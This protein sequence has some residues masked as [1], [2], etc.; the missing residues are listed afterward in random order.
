M[1]FDSARVSVAARADVPLHIDGMPRCL[2]RVDFANAL[3]RLSATVVA[4]IFFLS[5][6][7][8][9][10]VVVLALD[11]VML[12]ALLLPLALRHYQRTRTHEA[13]VSSLELVRVPMG[14][15]SSSCSESLAE[16]LRGADTL[17]HLRGERKYE[18]CLT[19]HRQTEQARVRFAAQLQQQMEL[20][21]ANQ[22]AEQYAALRA[23]S[24]QVRPLCAA[25]LDTGTNRRER[26]R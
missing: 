18:Q 14:S 22:N 3:E 17:A 19:V 23:L 9:A 10:A 12:L 13:A 1:H 20:S 5:L 26:Q 11:A 6:F 4:L 2:L 8:S 24:R 21:R 25:R 16:L 7:T 15:L